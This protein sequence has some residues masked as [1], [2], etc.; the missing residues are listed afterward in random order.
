MLVEMTY[1]LLIEMIR[2]KTNINLEMA[3]HYN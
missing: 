1:D 2:E 3:K